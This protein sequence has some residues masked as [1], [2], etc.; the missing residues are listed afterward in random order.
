[1]VVVVAGLI[2][3][4]ST[5][6]GFYV[7]ALVVISL[8]RF[9]L[10]ALSA[11]QPH[12]V[13]Q[14]ELVTANAVTSTIGALSAVVGAGAAAGVRALI[15]SA[16]GQYALIA[17]GAVTSYLLAAAVARRFPRTALGPDEVQ[18]RRG[19]SVADVA[20][21]L[22]QGARH[23]HGVPEVGRGLAVVGVQRLGY[24]LTL[25]CTVLLYRNYFHD[26]G[27]YRAGV[28]GLTQAI[29]AG[30]VGSALAALVTPAMSRRWG[31]TAWVSTLMLLGTVLQLACL[32]PFR[33]PL[34]LLGSLL[35]GVM[36]QGVKITVDTL[37]QQRIDDRFRGRVFSLYDA[38][39]NIAVV[40]AAVITALALPENGRSPA[41]VIA[42]GAA[43]A[44]A[45]AWY[46]RVSSAT[47]TT[48]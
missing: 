35:L 43:F 34:V 2:W 37:V 4:G 17:L 24:G 39:V 42:V 36:T 21:G 16:N 47:P 11:A 41:E 13:A 12:V 6:A 48:A 7:T 29:T 8:A 27:I 25:V 15:G 3:S 45:A 44:V 10:S 19:E 32:L 1:V 40:T 14:G 33:P 5:G 31:T 23:V 20:R 9:I 18:R 30:A 46:S 22:V 26:D 28:A 38:L